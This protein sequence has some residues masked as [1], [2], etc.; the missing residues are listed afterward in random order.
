VPSLFI[1]QAIARWGNFFNQELYGPPTDLPW[2][3]AIE[4]VHRVAAYPCSQFPFETT[5]FHPLFFYE[6]SLSLIGGLLALWIG[7]RFVD[8]L[9]PGDLFSFWLIWY[10]F[11]RAYLETF[12]EGWNWAV[13]GV[14]VATAISFLAIVF[15]VLTILWRHRRRAPEPQPPDREGPTPTA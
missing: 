11:V 2:G 3:I 9:R 5:G 8:R 14:P 10:G 15:G 1:S 6:A 4:C 13:Q 12:R 7:R